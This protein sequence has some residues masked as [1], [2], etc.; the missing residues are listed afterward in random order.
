MQCSI[1]LSFSFSLSYPATCL[2]CQSGRYLVDIEVEDEEAVVID[3]ALDYMTDFP[4]QVFA[5][6]SPSVFPT[7]PQASS[8]TKTD[9]IAVEANQAPSAAAQE[10]VCDG[11]EVI[12][13]AEVVGIV[14]TQ[15]TCSR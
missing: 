13:S 11:V 4:L 6:D 10:T 12:A 15:G 3:E 7:S 9:V 8:M 2:S 14:F 1:F 5:V